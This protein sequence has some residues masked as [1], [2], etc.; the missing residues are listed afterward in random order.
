MPSLV[1][2]IFSDERS[3][4]EDPPAGSGLEGERGCC[5]A[6]GEPGDEC[7]GSW[8]C[9]CGMLGEEAPAGGADGERARWGD[10]CNPGEE[11]T[12]SSAW[13]CMCCGMLG[14]EEPGG[15]D[16]ERA[17]IGEG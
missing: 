15:A 1:F 3:P 9:E 13:G 6:E 8:A 4:S 5:N 2:G 11:C 7:A 12:A 10:G 14:D 16:G 17:R